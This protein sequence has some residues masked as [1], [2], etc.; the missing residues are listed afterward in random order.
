MKVFE[1]APGIKVY[2]NVFDFNQSQI[3]YE[4]CLDN[5]YLIGWKDTQHSED[6]FIYSNWPSHYWA[7]A[8]EVKDSRNFLYI[9]GLSQPF[10]DEVQGKK[11]NKTIIN[12]GTIADSMSKH[13]H[14]GESVMLYYANLEWKSEW[15]GETLFY[16]KSGENVIY[17]SPFTPNR[18]IVFSGEVPHRFNPPSRVGP[19]FRFTISTFY[20]G[21][22]DSSDKEDP[23][24]TPKEP[25]PKQPKP[26]LRN[27][28]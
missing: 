3:I 26:S 2:D 21:S 18:M 16:D 22:V 24:E 12:C 13:T 6:A 15:G 19:K 23:K 9:L 14:L 11:I 25:K 28:L 5:E 20:E 10:I 17:T 1:P 7:R 8:M 4:Q 27:I